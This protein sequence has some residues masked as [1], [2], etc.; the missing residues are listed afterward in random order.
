[1]KLRDFFKEYYDWSE[2]IRVRS[3]VCNRA[4][5]EMI[6]PGSFKDSGEFRKMLS[7]N[8]DR[9]VYYREASK[10][11]DYEPQLYVTLTTGKMDFY[12]IFDTDQEF[13]DMVGKGL[14]KH[15]GYRK[16][17]IVPGGEIK[18]LYYSR[19]YE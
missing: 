18:Y 13:L 16:E 4:F 15:R 14:K 11:G 7:W 10:N 19:K 2:E 17:S 9:D 6:L 5:K 12:V 8:L 3:E 1:M